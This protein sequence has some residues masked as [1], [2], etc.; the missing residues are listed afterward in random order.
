MRRS[1]FAGSESDQTGLAR[2]SN[3]DRRSL[4]RAR[5]HPTLG[6]YHLYGRQSAEPLYTENEHNVQ[7]LWGLTNATPY[8][9][10]T[11]IAGW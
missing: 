7:R 6:A 9:K 4:G 10:D 2:D 3:A 11:S 5:Q 1:G 8:V